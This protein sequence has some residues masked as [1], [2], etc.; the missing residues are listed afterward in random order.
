MAII[1]HYDRVLESFSKKMYIINMT[2]QVFAWNFNFT[3]NPTEVSKTDNET[4]RNKRTVKV[5]YVSYGTFVFFGAQ[6]LITVTSF[7]QSYKV[8]RTMVHK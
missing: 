1:H 6:H 8:K 7:F 4:A 3:D 2:E 5:R